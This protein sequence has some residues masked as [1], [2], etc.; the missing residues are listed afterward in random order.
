M[1]QFANINFKWVLLMSLFATLYTGCMS[2]FEPK[3]EWYPSESS[4]RGYPI[5]LIRGDFSYGKRKSIYIPTS[6]D[7][8]GGWGNGIS[9]HAAG[10]L[11]KEVPH[12]LSVFFYS[13]IEDQF[14]RDEFVLDKD[15]L[16]KMFKEGHP[17]PGEEGNETYSF[18]NVN[19]APGGYVAMWLQGGGDRTEVF[20]EKATPIEVD[21]FSVVSGPRN[22][23]NREQYRQSIL[24]GDGQLALREAQEKGGIPFDRWANYR[25]SFN[26]RFKLVN[27]EQPKER[28]RMYFVN[29]EVHMYEPNGLQDYAPRHVPFDIMFQADVPDDYAIRYGMKLEQKPTFKAFEAIAKDGEPIDFVFEMYK[30][31]ST[32][33]NAE[34][35]QALDYD[36]FLNPPIIDAK[37]PKDPIQRH[38]RI[39]LANSQRRIEL[40]PYT[41]IKFFL[42][43]YWPQDK[44]L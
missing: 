30:E 24:N 6:A 8:G 20:F 40:N 33:Q 44:H 3:Y 26:W 29:G 15:Y 18:I 14:Y 31:T 36:G 11:E 7:L 22:S 38:Y 43:G 28:S 5:D 9:N 2:M 35:D 13:Y 1:T 39:Y 23:K 21:D 32:Q 16:S 17:V 42:A 27:I 4:P 41:K 34:Q 37:M 12:K 10:E 25:K 19:F